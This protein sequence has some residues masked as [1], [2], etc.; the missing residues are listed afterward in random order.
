MARVPEKPAEN[1]GELGHSMRT[2][3]RSAFSFV[4]R[5]GGKRW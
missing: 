3:V 5:K 4:K 1:A 2:M